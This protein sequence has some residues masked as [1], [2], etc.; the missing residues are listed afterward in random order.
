MNQ[1]AAGYYR[2]PI[3]VSP[4]QM[5]VI[6]YLDDDPVVTEVL[7]GGAAGGGKS[8]LLCLWQ[9]F[10]RVKYKNTR[11]LIGRQT[12]RSL[13]DTTMKTFVKVWNE[14]GRFNPYGVTMQ[15]IGHNAIFSNGSEILFR[16]VDTKDSTGANL[17][18][19]E[20]TD[21]AIDEVVEIGERVKQLLASRIRFNL[22]KGKPALL[23]AC[24]PA[25][26][27]VRDRFVMSV[28][29]K[30]AK[31][32]KY[33]K[34]VPARVDDNPDQEFAS[35]YRAELEKLSFADRQ[36]L[37]YGIWNYVENEKPFFHEFGEKH[38][39]DTVP[40][41]Q[42][43]PLFLSF[44]FNI[45]PAT[46]V[47]GQKLEYFGCAIQYTIQKT[48]GSRAL[49]EFVAEAYQFQNH[50]GGVL[51]T[52][53]YYGRSRTSAAGLNEF[54]EFNTDYNN[55]L[56]VFKLSDS[57]VIHT[58]RQ[59]PRII[60]SGRIVNHA[61]S[62]NVVKVRRETNG[63]LIRDLTTA[64]KDKRGQL[65]KNRDIGFGMDAGDAFRYWIHGNFPEGYKDI[66]HFA[67]IVGFRKGS[68]GGDF[69]SISE[70]FKQ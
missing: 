62:Q 20:L 42:F 3:K 59:N 24:N 69:D 48:G 7:F 10:R 11:G 15:M 19:L 17:G 37:L 30:P 23:M 54:G 1:T 67:E 31:L 55:I 61:F 2:I 32:E 34:F 8:F 36:R 58:Q 41:D 9:I 49:A 68:D 51:I 35:R 52:G 16:W 45:D 65:V 13:Q 18:S 70:H 33:Q 26:N 27:W 63:E 4:K 29:G 50:V 38:V 39:V 56:D 53:D 60:Y 21:A 12:F 43:E 66:N 47:V 14:I 40:V 22:I 57:V 44:D 6:R 64:Q 5:T 46:V 28:D 25:A